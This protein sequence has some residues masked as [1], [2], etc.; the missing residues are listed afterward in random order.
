MT[1]KAQLVL[2]VVGSECFVWIGKDKFVCK[3]LRQATKD[4]TLQSLN[5]GRFRVA[6][7]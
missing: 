5:E 3:I 2:K 4:D 1:V 6:L 7:V